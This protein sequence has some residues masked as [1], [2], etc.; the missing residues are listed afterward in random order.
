M[1]FRSSGFVFGQS[2]SGRWTSKA[3]AIGINRVADFNS[4][5]FYKGQNDYSSFAEPLANEFAGSRLS[6]DAALN[7]NSVSLLTKM[8]LYTYLVDT[9]TINGNPQV[10]ARSEQTSL[11]N[12]QNR[13]SSSG[14][15][16]EI[17]LGYAANMDDRLFL[18]LSLGIPLVNYRRELAWKEE[19]ALGKGNNEFSYST[20][21]ETYTSKGAGLNAKLGII[22]KPAPQLR[23]GLSIHTP[24]LYG[25]RD[26]IYASMTTDLDTATGSQKVFSVN[27]D[28]LYSNQNPG[29]EYDLTTPWRILFGG[30]WVLHEDAD[31]TRQRGFITAEIEYVAHR[32]SKFSPAQRS[33]EH[34]SELQSH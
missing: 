31:V 17:S 8:A 21:N 20:Y 33:E 18:G 23:L 28:A 4:T 5:M 9:T 10:I 16:S 19:D 3:F 15:I 7:S 13:I 6:I 12:Q 30:A 29:F 22:F 26:N 32:G 34:T 24:T 14:G 1:L 2:S 27:T 25:L 11:L